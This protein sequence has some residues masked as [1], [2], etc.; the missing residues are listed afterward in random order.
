MSALGRRLCT[1]LRIWVSW[2]A[3]D[4]LLIGLGV[5]FLHFC[6]KGLIQLTNP[7]PETQNPKPRSVPSA[8]GHDADR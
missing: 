2:K 8:G 6:P 1:T 7:K 3:L 4:S 5:G